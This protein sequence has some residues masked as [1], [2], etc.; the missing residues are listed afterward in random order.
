MRGNTSILTRSWMV[1]L[2]I[3]LT[4]GLMPV[5]TFAYGASGQQVAEERPGDEATEP[6]SDG[7]TEP[8]SDDLTEPPTPEEEAASREAT[9]TA[10]VEPAAELPAYSGGSGTSLDPYLISTAA[11]LEALRATTNTTA[12]YTD[13]T[14]FKLTAD[15]DLAGTTWDKGIGYYEGYSSNYSF[16]GY[17]DGAGHTIRN[18][19]V[20]VTKVYDSSGSSSFAGLFGRIYSATIKDLSVEGSV[21]NTSSVSSTVLRM[22][23]YTAGIAGCVFYATIEG[24]S[25]DV[26]VTDSGYVGSAYAK[27]GSPSSGTACTGGIVGYASNTSIGGCESNG[28]VSTTS[29]AVGGIAGYINTGDTVANCV[30]N[31][32][33]VSAYY[34]AGGVIGI[35]GGYQEKAYNCGNNGSVT[36]TAT[37]Q[38]VAQLGTD[39]PAIPNAIGGVVGYV[40][41][42][43]FSL[44]SS[45]NKGAV[46]STA[47]TVGGVVGSLGSFSWS[48][49]SGGWS[50]VLSTGSMTNCYNAATVSTDASDGNAAAGGVVGV[51]PTHHSTVSTSGYATVQNCLNIGTVSAPS[52]TTGYSGA[53]AGAP[54]VVGIP[55]T[56]SSTITNNYYL[57][58]SS[59]AAFGASAPGTARDLSG[60]GEARTVA[61]TKA[62]TSLGSVYIVD[63]TNSF[64]SGYPYLAWENPDARFAVAIN[65]TYD[66]V[67]N[68]GESTPV[69][70]VRDSG[71]M[72]QNFTAGVVDETTKALTFSGA[73][74]NG[75]YTYTLVQQG[76]GT[77][78][79]ASV[80][81]PLSGTFVVNKSAVS[82]DAKL[83][84]KK[85]TY[86]MTYTPEDAKVEGIY[87]N[88]LGTQGEEDLVQDD[89]ELGLRSVGS[90][91]SSPLY[92]GSY[93]YRVSKFGYTAQE[94]EFTLSYA[95]GSGNVDLVEKAAHTLRVTLTAPSG[96]QFDANDAPTLQI[97]ATDASKNSFDMTLTAVVDSG[98]T[99]KATVEVDLHEF[100]ASDPAGNNIY[101]YRLKATG[102]NLM[103]G[104]FDLSSDCTETITLEN[105]DKWD[106][107]Y[108]IS[109]Y[110]AQNPQDEYVIT[111]PEQL[112]GLSYLVH[113]WGAGNTASAVTSNFAGVT[114]KLGNDLDLGGSVGLS[115]EP[116]GYYTF[117]CTFQ[118][119]FDGQGYTVRGLNID[120]TG[121]NYRG[122]FGGMTNGSIKNL[123]V[124][125]TVRG[126]TS[127]AG[128]LGYAA[129]TT[130]EGC[131]SNVAVTVAGTGIYGGGIVGSSGNGNTVIRAC[132]NEGAVTV[133]NKSA[134]VGG[135]IGNAT[136]TVAI[137]N[138]SNKGD[139]SGA[140]GEADVGSYYL[141]G[142]GGVAGAAGSNVSID[143][144]Y[145]TGWVSGV[146]AGGIAGRSEAAISN[147]YNAGAVS[148]ANAGSL[149]GI[150]AVGGIVGNA[151]ASSTSSESSVS[152]VNCF[153]RGKTAGALIGENRIG[154]VWGASRYSKPSPSVG[155]SRV[156][157]NYA[158]SGQGAVAAFGGYGT[159]ST[160]PFDVVGAGD[161]VDESALK[162]MTS[163]L[164][165][166]YSA[167]ETATYN[168]GFPYLRW[169]NPSMT[170][171]VRVNVDYDDPGNVTDIP[172][173]VKVFETATGDE[174]SPSSQ[175]DGTVIFYLENG[176]YYYTVDQEGYESVAA[177][178]FTVDGAAVSL[179]VQLEIIKYDLTYTVS[180][181]DATLI[182]SDS[183]DAVLDPIAVDADTGTY[184]YSV[185]N[186][187]YSYVL[188]KFGYTPTSGTTTVAF[189][190]ITQSLSIESLPVHS[191]DISVE[192]VSGVFGSQ[193]ATV[194]IHSNGIQMLALTVAPGTDGV[195][196]LSEE[197][198][199]GDYTYVAGASGF[200]KATGSFTVSGHDE[201]VAI[202][203][204]AKD[205][206]GGTAD[207]TWAA[208]DSYT[209]NDTF[210]LVSE[211]ELAGLA[212]L[213][214]QGKDFSNKT[215]ILGIDM[216]LA[217][218]NWNPIGRYGTAFS[219]TFD[220]ADHSIDGLNIVKKPFTSS[221]SLYFG[222]FGYLGSSLVENVVVR[223]NIKLDPLDV[224][225]S[226]V[227][228]VGGIAAATSTGSQA[229][230][231]RCG[232]E[233]NITI[234]NTIDSIAMNVG[235]IVGWG[236][237]ASFEECYNAATIDV[238]SETASLRAQAKV[239]GLAGMVTVAGTELPV[240]NCFNTGSI[241]VYSDKYAY[242]GGL[243]GSYAGY[244]NSGALM[245]MENVYN[246]GVVQASTDGYVDGTETR[247]GALVGDPLGNNS[248]SVLNAY[249]L[250]SSAPHAF[251]TGDNPSAGVYDIT[252]QTAQALSSE[253]TVVALNAGSNVFKK[254]AAVGGYPLF[255]WQEGTES[256]EI[257][258]MPDKTSYNDGEN[259]DTTGMTL[260][261]IQA[262]ST[263][264]IASGWTVV[265]GTNLR[266]GQTYVTINY[267]GLTL[268]CP[269][270]VTQIDHPIE[271]SLNFSITPPATDG[272]PQVEL[273]NA[274]NATVDAAQHFTTS[275]VWTKA[276]VPMQDTT[277]AQTSYYR[278]RVTFTSEY[279]DEA[280]YVFAENTTVTVGGAYTQLYQT[281][282]LDG[283]TITLTLTFPPTSSASS[284]LTPSAS[285]LYYEG[286]ILTPLFSNCLPGKNALTLTGAGIQTATLSL[287]DIEESVLRD[288]VGSEDTYSQLAYGKIIRSIYTGVNLYRFLQEYGFVSSD[289]GDETA[290]TLTRNDGSVVDITVGDIRRGGTVYDGEG[291]ALA[292]VP[293]QLSFAANGVP[294]R[295]P[296]DILS[297]NGPLCVNLG[298]QSATDTSSRQIGNVVGIAIGTPVYSLQHT[299]KFDVYDGSGSELSGVTVQVVD[300]YDNEVLKDIDNSFNLNEGETYTYIVSKDGYT[301]R[302]D[303]V[304][305]EKDRTITLNLIPAW[306]GE[307]LTAPE[308]DDE[309]YYLIGTAD[310]LVWW[311]RNGTRTD[312]VRLTADIALSDAYT[313]AKSG[314]TDSDGDL[315]LD[316]GNWLPMFSKEDGA[317]TGIFDGQ[318]HTI[319]G[320][321][322]NRE[323]SYEIELD[324]I[325]GAPLLFADR[326]SCLGMFGYTYGATIKGLGVVGKIEVLDRPDSL[327]GDWMQVGGIVGL[328]Q[329]G[330]II[331]DCYTN[332]S[333]QVIQ[334]TGSG[335]ITDGDGNRYS[336]DGNA[337]VCDHYIGGIAGS[338]SAET[339]VRD[340]HTDGTYIGGAT[341]SVSVGGIVGGM[342]PGSATAEVA[343]CYS[344]AT[345]AGTPLDTVENT[346]IESCF[347]GIV[348]KPDALR[349]T[350][351][352]SSLLSLSSELSSAPLSNS[353]DVIVRLSAEEE[354]LG[355]VV[356]EGSVD[357]RATG[358][359]YV[360]GCF[361]LNEVISGKYDESSQS[362]RSKAGRVCGSSTGVLFTNNYAL[363]S[364]KVVNAT[365]SSD[366]AP[367]GTDITVSDA[368]F[369]SSY[370]AEGW[371]ESTWQFPD[372]IYPLLT[373]QNPED[374]VPSMGSTYRPG[375]PSDDE[376][377]DF[378]VSV[379]V[380]GHDPLLLKKYSYSDMKRMATRDSADGRKYY[381]SY[382][383][384]GAA[385]RVVTE[386]VYLD[387][388]LD[389]LG[390]SFGSGDAWGMGID[391]GYD[392]YFATPRYYFPQWD[393]GSSEGKVE[394]EPVIAIKSYGAS[395]GCSEDVLEMYA[396]SADTLWAY[397]LNF[398]QRTY[399]DMT[400]P[401]FS[402]QQDGATMTY[403]ATAAA[404]E[405][406]TG[407]LTDLID[408]CQVDLESTAEGQDVDKVDK[409][410]QFVTPEEY[411]EFDAALSAARKAIGASNATNDSVMTAYE[412]LLAAQNV[413]DGAKKV[414][415]RDS[416]AIELQAALD[417]A[418]SEIDKI[419]ISK[420]GTDVGT[421]DYWVT[422]DDVEQ[423]RVVIDQAQTLLL[424]PGLLTAAEI[425]EATDKLLVAIEVFYDTQER[426]TA[427][428]G[429]IVRIQGLTR[430]ETAIASSQNAH[431]L[432]SDTVIIAT[433]LE[434]PD[435][436]TGSSLAGLTDAPILLTS[437]GA[438]SDETLAEVK[439]LKAETVYIVG[440]VAAVPAGVEDQL[441]DAGV[442]Q[443]ER[444]SGEVRTDTALS[445]YEAGRGSWGDTAIIAYGFK[446]ADALSIAPYATYATTPIFL[447][448]NDT[449]VGEKTK[450]AITSGGFDRIVIV[451]GTGVVSGETEAMLQSIGIAEDDI[452]RLGGE[453]RYE[454]NV[455]I[456]A[457]SQLPAQG[458]GISNAGFAIGGQRSGDTGPDK[459]FA[460]ALTGSGLLAKHES[461]L[462]LV[463]PN[464]YDS[465]VSFVKP[466]A[467]SVDRAY[468]FGGTGALPADFTETLRD[469]LK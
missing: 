103:R 273:T 327:Q 193:G 283:R 401:Y 95:N 376:G 66:D 337:E 254:N 51:L 385:G 190:D 357:L 87:K 216:N 48:S 131:I 45:Y 383:A 176:T 431:P 136:Y 330:T 400:Y 368:K 394:I 251:G 310:E 97:T 423:L 286:D 335:Y 59:S 123:T 165:I 222:L 23:K 161:T 40:N 130:I 247:A 444:L 448:D 157:N 416:S 143:A 68:R 231:Y 466:Q 170:F 20:V 281:R 101:D 5:S 32:T 233:V 145:N 166:A 88:T 100:D 288:P 13:G 365:Q 459:M 245:K 421:G 333:I 242:A 402:R 367:N 154:G 319:Y 321:Y 25:S 14:C 364:M 223:G 427:D 77:T 139:V 439:R 197:L 156:V 33:I 285:H 80:D 339:S 301:T 185:N 313:Y 270:T 338:T 46:S 252:V 195:V 414:G 446:Y 141:Y 220:G 43:K 253:A 424:S 289:V 135:I 150:V 163:A 468:I 28:A 237:G 27:G 147:C 11:D 71:G 117:A 276:G 120:N 109:W 160:I 457:W 403:A 433:G 137:E 277:F 405:T 340:C 256:I 159:S 179:D 467:S 196:R 134:T 207:T 82:L 435:A 110:D 107:S 458:L 148:G 204:D 98:D 61:E 408:A 309:G 377:F 236:I 187:S 399:S 334:A 318:G 41:G 199:E 404:N 303:T 369:A 53:I 454:T 94:H 164:G 96:Q 428:S 108:D 243:V 284:G 21:A 173:S 436:L 317:F 203:L 149:P 426:G 118:G 6:S 57:A 64:N 304:A 121:T 437:N 81:D 306:D 194:L 192:P 392:T 90:R 296:N 132:V 189:S 1:L 378:S 354:Q 151:Y 336:L 63:D 323:N 346:S 430:T 387:T 381:S 2:A 31:G 342:R 328:A 184:T 294:L 282:S 280:H 105:K 42:G 208:G 450:E 413:F 67:A 169:Q 128:L 55:T 228:A 188:K 353:T 347:G 62:L 316:Q 162:N 443:V 305:L 469:A 44:D 155:S 241:S 142:S 210:T 24:C 114:F 178:D 218:R 269:I 248:S 244:N 116:I 9:M 261:V 456:A 422:I 127:S 406:I 449:V 38:Q 418:L 172:A 153:N 35:V 265:D 255:N 451:G 22:S 344:T 201:T 260:K 54:Y 257:A 291:A 388:I 262:N 266:P 125:G 278:A 60:S 372:A 146:S 129:G 396:G 464:N 441:I 308:K 240:T 232:N 359:S 287:K 417:V 113:K 225:S 438:L 29:F 74:E 15:I 86:T 75:T 295:M 212:T 229:R 249:Y 420:D 209:D 465:A 126:G 462:L 343:N 171:E 434:F 104:T 325:A 140:A 410:V 91:T 445:I 361:A 382:S 89:D 371:Q 217:G 83:I 375:T 234:V 79:N 50:S 267:Q 226:G 271:A 326:V 391:Y 180:P 70:S 341:R 274:D 348:G 205:G 299:L 332:M 374:I 463:N 409:G 10:R 85:Y 211:E 102:S 99:T 238:R 7:L 36:S 186:G 397:V 297:S 322:I 320:L 389:D 380:S 393:S 174:V 331:S 442:S 4:F 213:V 69:L 175:S 453:T 182:V 411:Q 363:S 181:L 293:A 224:T 144:C 258:T 268:Q 58:G 440:G 221:T 246:S 307:T 429:K 106:G 314:A 345:I 358:T 124:E 92:N 183:S 227:C 26:V 259:F 215:V 447:T 349:Y 452:V 407:I 3:I 56:T 298:M 379:G 167:D 30:N 302:S 177:T 78:S 290:V 18:L 39:A 93:Y 214:N 206:W 198:P 275:V 362:T 133:T 419:V 76:Y 415:V 355:C 122:L 300:E 315:E 191:V 395:S 352:L 279:T 250:D 17:F 112:A 350:S 263:R 230:F 272:I 425:T 37:A 324:T 152:V 386:Y 390:L 200:A 111:T 65:V 460:D 119:D 16:G 366:Q 432:G 34:F 158:L 351:E 312:N 360:A 384:A 398:G 370:T 219:G 239:G 356:E 19:N 412:N 12:G 47:V 311:N 202:R 84:G 235:G 455:Q 168:D 373:W 329:R 73:L 72:E 264:I 115:W 52:I 461:I 138:C 49:Y 8:S 292:A